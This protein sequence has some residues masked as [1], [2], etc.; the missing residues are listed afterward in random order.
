MQPV[1]PFSP[2]AFQASL[3][4][5]IFQLRN[6]ASGDAMTLIKERD[7]EH[8]PSPQLNTKI[9]LCPPVSQPDATGYSV[10]ETD[11]VKADPSHFAED[12]VAEHS[13]S[14]VPVATPGPVTGSVGPPATKDPKSAKA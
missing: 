7:A 4:T 3:Q 11:A 1:F 8:H 6:Q 2:L 12:F 13:T 9:H 5:S 10:V 14:G